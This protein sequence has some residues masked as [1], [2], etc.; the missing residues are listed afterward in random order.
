VPEQFAHDNCSAY[1]VL[2]AKLDMVYVV[3]GAVIV[4]GV[5]VDVGEETL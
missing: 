3:G 4:D 1:N 5:V 2:D